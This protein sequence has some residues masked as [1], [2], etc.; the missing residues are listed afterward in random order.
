MSKNIRFTAVGENIHCT[1]IYKVGGKF[2]KALDDGSQVIAYAVDGQERHL[3]IPS[4]FVESEDWA[5]KKV[6]HAAVAIWQGIYGDEAAQQAGAAYLHNMVRVQEAHGAGFLDLN[7]DEF[8]NDLD[9]RVRVVQ[10]AV[11]VLQQ[12]ASAPLSIDSSSPEILQAGLDAYNSANGRPMVN[13]V[14]L[15]RA[16]SIEVARAANAVVIA[17]AT[18]ENS[19]PT[20]VED[21]VHNFGQ[22]VPKLTD[23]GFAYDDIYLDPL[24]FPASVDSENGKRVLEAIR[25]LREQYGPEIHFAP[26]LSNVSYGLPNRK[27]LN[28]VFAYLCVENGCDGGIVDP[29][30]VNAQALERLDATTEGFA[31]AKAFLMGEDEFGMN[32]IRAARK[33]LL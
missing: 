12:A 27:L 28:Q 14:S 15:E 17:G 24:V 9:E 11:G 16:A 4:R 25:A 32:Y 7:V 22:L 5:R 2:V 20:T 30:H 18:G 29:R 26:G 21:R 8:S 10:W 13:S 23:A 3:P 31:L 6:K 19:M 1:R 33:G